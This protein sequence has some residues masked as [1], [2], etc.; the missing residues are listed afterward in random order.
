MQDLSKE[1]AE[2]AP[3]ETFDPNAFV[4]NHEVPQNICNFLLTLALAYN[5]CKN[6][7]YSNLLLADFKPTGAP[8]RSRF[9]GAYSGIKFHYL[10]FIWRFCMS[11]SD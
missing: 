3:L 4:G 6:G 11:C 1:I 2:L 10:D 7:I 8:K 9:W 5:D